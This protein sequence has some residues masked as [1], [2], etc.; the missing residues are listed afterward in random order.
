MPFLFSYVCDL[1]QA[2]DDN[3]RTKTGQK[4]TADIVEEWFTKHR[5]L[6]NRDDHDD[7]ALLS[8]LFPEKRTD[9]VFRYGLKRLEGI[10]GRGLGLGMTRKEEL[11]RHADAK[12]SMDLAESVERILRDTVRDA[13]LDARFVVLQVICNGRVMVIL[14][15]RYETDVDIA[16]P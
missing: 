5:S 8:T 13:I 15:G 6:I 1:L 14:V 16:K 11:G 10:I 12:W 9:R 2:L 4:P 3:Q 7:T